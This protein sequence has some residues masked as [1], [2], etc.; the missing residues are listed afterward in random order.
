MTIEDQTRDKKNCNMTL[1]ERLQKYQPYHRAKLIS[2][3]I[4]PVK[5]YFLLINNK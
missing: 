3:N 5:K 2:M 4:L 1:I